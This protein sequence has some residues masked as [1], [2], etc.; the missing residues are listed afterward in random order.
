M[1][2]KV[3][4]W[5]VFLASCGYT[6]GAVPDWSPSAAEL[7][8]AKRWVAGHLGQKRATLPFSFTYDGKSSAELLA[9]W[10]AQ[11]AEK[12]LDRHR[13]ERTLSYAD[14]KTGLRVRCIAV[15]YNDYPT[16]EWT[17]YFENAGRA[18]SPILE[19]IR[20]IDTGFT[21]AD[22]G[23]FTLHG[24]RGDDTTALSYQPYDVALPPG[25]VKH[26]AS[27]GGKSTFGDYPYFNVE[28]AD[29]GAIVVL[30][31]PG[32]WA[33]EFS[34]D[35][36]TGLR[37]SGGQQTTHFTLHP[38]EEVRTPLAVVQ[39]YKGEPVRA[40]NIW[41]R[42]MIAHN[43][44]RTG[45]G[46]TPPPMLIM[47]DGNYFPGLLTS[48]AGEKQWI[49]A[50]IREDI[51]PDYWWIDAG[52]YPTPGEWP[53]V[54]TWEP[55]KTR[56]PKGLKAVSDYVHAR[57]MKLIVWFE[58]ERASAGSWLAQNHPE[59]IIGGSKGG[60]VNL[61]NPDAWKWMVER[62]DGLLVSEGIDLYREDFNMDPLSSW[63]AN[64]TP[65]R[66]GITENKH[67]MGHLAYWDELKRRH[68]GMLIDSCAGGGRRNDLETL[69]RAVPLLRSDYQGEP[70]GNQGHTYGLSSWVPFYGTGIWGDEYAI[71]SHFCPS[72]GI[73]IDVRKEGND[74]AFMR[75]MYRDWRKV[76]QYMVADY[77]PLTPYSPAN[78]AWMAWQF[79]SP[80][81]GE[82]LVQAFRR[83]ENREESICLKLHGL[84][85]AAQYTVTDLDSTEP[86]RLSGQELMDR[87]LTL[88]LLKAPAAKIITYQK[89]K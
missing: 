16:V 25:T 40:Q 84:D 34:R 36:G 3:V 81:K 45:H 44:P 62:V 66:Q 83:A 9:T 33:A 48:E 50:Y 39:F 54:G 64:D 30:G 67:V 74:Y 55:D 21:R 82:G 7:A 15:A 10:N 60:L 78:D 43:V 80:E 31:W 77:Y 32:Q 1:K 24:N 53:L 56:Y 68:P 47:C 19:N 2:L 61:G 27:G 35:N 18:D 29:Q 4:V 86:Q 70:V 76:S 41:R 5:L 88:D 11:F 8:T 17:L 37:V 72:L 22:K 28:W 71:R 42:W 73:A 46:K 51:K 14:P 52:W 57:G 69:R 75:R 13:T 87:G 12:K 63:Q 20:A 85:P 38:G 49:D 26:L 6:A 23:E 65:D 59:W 58:P 79:N 89:L